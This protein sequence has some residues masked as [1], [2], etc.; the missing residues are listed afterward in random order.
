MRFALLTKKI[1]SN[2]VQIYSE[3]CKETLG[4]PGQMV[5]L[6]RLLAIG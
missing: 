4:Y 5:E 3:R 6:G 2:K 1:F